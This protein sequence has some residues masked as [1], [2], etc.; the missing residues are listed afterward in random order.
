MVP[1]SKACSISAAILSLYSFTGAVSGA[2]AHGFIVNDKSAEIEN[3]RRHNNL[4]HSAR[5]QER[6]LDVSR[7]CLIETYDEI[8]K[9]EPPNEPYIWNFDALGCV[10]SPCDFKDVHA[11]YYQAYMDYCD[12]IGAQF[13]LYTLTYIENRTDTDPGVQREIINVPECIAQSCDASQFASYATGLDQE[14]AKLYRPDISSIYI[15]TQS[16]SAAFVT[17]GT[18][19]F[20]V[21]LAV[22]STFLVV[23]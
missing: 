14:Q 10:E 19:A 11:F 22:S 23:N 7:E 4:K 1:L 6:Q 20:A 5:H 13:V 2:A 18:F 12:S 8:P 17:A 16:S 21:L 3:I 15:I 9:N